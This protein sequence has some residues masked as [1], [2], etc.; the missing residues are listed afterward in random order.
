MIHGGEPSRPNTRQSPGRFQLFSGL[1][2]S[3]TGATPTDR[4]HYHVIDLLRGLAACAILFWHYQHFIALG[5]AS[6]GSRVTYPLYAIFWPFYEYGGTAVQ[7]FW[8]VSG[9][10]FSAV[11]AGTETQT[12]DFV[13]HRFARLY[14]LHFV[15][16]LVVGGLQLIALSRFGRPLIYTHNDALDFLLQLFMA[17]GWGLRDAFSFNGPVWSV[18]AEV[19][20]YGLFWLTLRF[21]FRRGVLYPLIFAAVA[22]VVTRVTGSAVASC[23]F[24]F[25]VGCALFAVH[26]GWADSRLKQ[27]VVAAA[28]IA[29]SPIL[30]QVGQSGIGFLF[31]F[32]GL[33]LA[34]ASAESRR[35]SRWARQVPWLAD[36]TYGS[37][38]WH[39]PIQLMLLILLD[40]AHIDRS[41][42]LGVPFLLLFLALVT[43]TARASFLWIESPARQFINGRPRREPSN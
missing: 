25:Y 38:L 9:F 24:Y 11:Y 5:M 30:G 43:L 14:P 2:D 1:F 16:L 32:S 8:I 26:R 29:M 23:F 42:A 17:S 22:L 34:C 33:T 37:Y 7:L 3:R 12:K 28:C 21:L 40:V 15:T 35:L 39:I 19:L 18:S 10:I 4:R 41:I 31:L 20:T 27:N 13:R 36:N 6:E